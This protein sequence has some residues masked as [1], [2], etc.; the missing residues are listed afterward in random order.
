M[1]KYQHR[2]NISAT[3][4]GFTDPNCKKTSP[5]A[6]GLQALYNNTDK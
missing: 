3:G 6:Q 2:L 5:Q 1:K 4:R